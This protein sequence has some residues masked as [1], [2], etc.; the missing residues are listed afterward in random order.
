MQPTEEQ[1]TAIKNKYKV[2]D[3]V[4]GTVMAK[5][6]FGDWIDIG[7]G[8]LCLLEIICIKGLAPE[9]YRSGDYNPIG[10]IVTAAIVSFQDDDRQIRLSTV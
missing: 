3:T 2:G 6:P 5:S 8:C 7:E 4:E 1:W 9:I 10:S